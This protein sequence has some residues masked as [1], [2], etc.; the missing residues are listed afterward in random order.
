RD[1]I[2]KY[3]Q[4][5][6]IEFREDSSNASTKYLRNKLRHHILPLFRQE[7]QQFEDVMMRNIKNLKMAQDFIETSLEKSREEIVSKRDQEVLQ[8]NLEKLR[9]KKAYLF[10]LYNI[11]EEF[12]FTFDTTISLSDK[13]IITGKQFFSSTHEALIDRGQLLIRKRRMLFSKEVLIHE[14]GEYEFDSN[15]IKIDA[16]IKKLPFGAS[17]Y[18]EQF[19]RD[20]LK[21]P[22]KLRKWTNGDRMIP[23][24]MKTSKLV[25]D[26]LTDAKLSKFEKEKTLVIESNG[27][28][29]WLVGQRISEL[30]KI[31]PQTNNIISVSLS[32]KT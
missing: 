30:V 23:L 19:D 16:Q 11:L 31:T 18:L 21:F 4:I 25:S 22:L 17:K 8:I 6:Q 3:A 5:N 1:E 29:V 24:G 26:M 15:I 9:S 27:I 12:N 14:L 32:S 13:N 7:N 10:V 2:R 20:K 28:I